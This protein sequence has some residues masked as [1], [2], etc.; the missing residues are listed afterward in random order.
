LG[1]KRPYTDTG[2]IRGKWACN[3]TATATAAIAASTAA[4][5][6]AASTAAAA[7]KVTTTARI[8]F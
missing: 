1:A 4:A 8:K 2:N 5:V 7:A 3:P 6:A